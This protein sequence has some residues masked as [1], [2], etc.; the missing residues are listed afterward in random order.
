MY[1]PAGPHLDR[2]VACDCTD[3]AHRD[4][5]TCKHI[6]AV[7]LW[8][9]REP[10]PEAIPDSETTAFAAALWKEVDQR[11]AARVKDRAPAS[12]AWRRPGAALYQLARPS[13]F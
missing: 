9:A 4:L 6:E 1:L 7:R 5:G 10:W 13:T 8:L 12:L 11:Q 2:E 3:F